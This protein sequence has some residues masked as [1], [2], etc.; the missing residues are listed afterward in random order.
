MFA[1]I[2]LFPYHFFYNVPSPTV[3]DSL[4]LPGALPILASQFR[5]PTVEVFATIAKF[6]AV[7]ILWFRFPTVEVFAT[8]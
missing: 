6:F 3:I 4:T 1:T 5:F 7:S 2:N 8:I